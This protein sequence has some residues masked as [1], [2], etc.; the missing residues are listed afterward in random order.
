MADA[1]FAFELE[2]NGDAALEQAAALEKLREKLVADT[3][4]LSEMNKAFRALK[5]SAH[6]GGEGFKR[7]KDQIAAQKASIANAH[8]GFLQLGGDFKKIKKPTDD[9]KTGFE[10]FLEKAKGSGGPLGKLTGGLEKLRGLGASGVMAAGFAG[11][12]AALVALAAAALVATAALFKFGIAMADAVRSERLQL[13]GL[14]RVRNWYGLAA[15]K[16]GFLQDAISKVAASSAL[17]RDEINGMA[18]SLY[19]AG[20]RGGSLQQALEGVATATSAAGAE[21]GE[22]YKGWFLGMARSGQ[23]TKK[24]AD[25]IK[26]RFGGVAKAQ[27]LSLGVQSK[28]LRESFQQLFSGLRIESFL[29]AMHDVTDLFSQNTFSGRALKRILETLFNPMAD[30]ASGYGIYFKRFFQGLVI[31]A[32][33]LTLGV[34]KLRNWLRQTF[35]DVEIFQG[36]DKQRLAVLAG[37]SAV[38]ALVAALGGLAAI[39]TIAFAPVIIATGLIGAFIYGCYRA[40]KAITGIDWLGAG[41]SLV[42]GIVNGIKNGAQWVIDA[43]KNLAAKALKAFKEK[44]SIASPS[45]VFAKLGLELPR[46]MA[47]GVKAGT[48]FAE[49]AVA[50]MANSAAESATPAS[51]AMYTP[52]PQQS[53]SARG[54]SSA[55][56]PVLNLTLNVTT[57]ATDTKGVVDEIMRAVRDGA[58]QLFEGV[59]IQIG[60]E[61][62]AT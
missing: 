51:P 40:Y 30:F 21:Q 49:N 39:M 47:V 48:P 2:G 7:L 18:T 1:V 62:P 29:Q 5:G 33:L 50:N 52:P 37:A 16:A 43:I 20:L 9:A 35:G 24:L 46:G 36:I 59:A 44:L 11:I 58:T 12:A 56:A 31:G 14:T 61:A 3:A 28:K 32:Q 45:K 26:A 8:A 27:L 60:A 17:G 22:M 38:G 23:A 42:G 6:A 19:K 25:D 10:H 55:A 13:E 15:D 41:K 34:L 4:A 53:R 57:Q 54:A